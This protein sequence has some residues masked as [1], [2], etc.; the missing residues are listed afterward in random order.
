LAVAWRELLSTRV[1]YPVYCAV[2]TAKT[3]LL[4]AAYR[5]L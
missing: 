3:C 4:R 2:V 5:V 1:K